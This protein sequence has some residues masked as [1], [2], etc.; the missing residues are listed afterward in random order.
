MSS[1]LINTVLMWSVTWRL[2]AGILL[3]R[4]PSGVCGGGPPWRRDPS[5][6]GQLRDSLHNQSILLATGTAHIHR[7]SLASP[8]CAGCNVF[9]IN[10]SRFED[11]FV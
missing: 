4:F 10:V 1:L 5:G 6:K 7:L 2:T 3:T 11:V 9:L 8:T